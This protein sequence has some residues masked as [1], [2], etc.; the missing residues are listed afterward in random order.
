MLE[1]VKDYKRH[2]QGRFYTPQTPL[3]R[4]VDAA[5]AESETARQFAATVDSLLAGTA[6]GRLRRTAATAGQLR[7]LRQQLTLWQANNAHLQPLLLLNESLHEYA[8]HSV[9]LTEVAVLLLERLGQLEQGQPAP[10]GWAARARAALDAAAAPAGQA[11]LALIPAA[12]RL[13][14]VE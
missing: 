11:E 2:F 13:A 6:S 4:L 1:P 3:N 7:R 10:A 9:R 5:P 12:R 14:E 8:P